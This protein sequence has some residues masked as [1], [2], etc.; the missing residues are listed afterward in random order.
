VTPKQVDALRRELLI[1]AAASRKLAVALTIAWAQLTDDRF[2][3]SKSSTNS[4][5]A[6]GVQKE[7]G[8]TALSILEGPDAGEYPFE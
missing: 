5:V 7:T 3:G 8:P 2:S 6:D 1:G 4:A